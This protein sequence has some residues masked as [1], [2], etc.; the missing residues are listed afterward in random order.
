MRRTLTLLLA[1]LPLAGCAALRPL[2]PDSASVVL[3][4]VSHILQH[5]P[6]ASWIGYRPTN[7]GFQTI[8]MEARWSHGPWYFSI[9]DGYS[10][11]DGWLPGPR[12]VFEARAG[13]I[14]W[15]RTSPRHHSP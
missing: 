9:A 1:L 15:A 8:S 4:H 7:Y 10:L 11:P 2:E 6:C 3:T 13:Y 12:E 5:N 14:F